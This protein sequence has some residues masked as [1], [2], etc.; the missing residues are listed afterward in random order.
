MREYTIRP[1][2]VGANETDQGIMTYLKDYGKRIWI[3][4]YAF[5][6]EGG[7]ETILVDT[8]L[9]E[10]MVPDHVAET[11]NLEILEFEDALAAAGLRPEDVDVIIHTHLHNDHCENDAKCPNA[12]IIVQEEE[13]AFFQNPHPLDHRYYPDL[14]DGLKV[15]TVRGDVT[16]RDGIDLIFTPGHT[17]G[18]QS[19]AVNTSAGRAIITGFCCN[20]KNFPSTGPAVTPGVHTDALAAYDSIQ[21]IRKMADI[22]I[23]LHDLRIG[24]LKQIPWNQGVMSD[25]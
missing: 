9:E 12:T 6:I 21:K 8:G 10:F 1:L 15:E 2:V 11:Y 23:P 16:F 3:P 22:L 5:V 13:Y 19:V 20:D 25:G 14:L 4:I 7:D 17:P 24:A 18:G